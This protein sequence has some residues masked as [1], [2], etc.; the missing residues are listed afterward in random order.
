MPRNVYKCTVMVMMYMPILGVVC[1]KTGRSR[2]GDSMVGL[3]GIILGTWVNRLARH[4][5]ALPPECADA[6]IGQL[7]AA[8]GQL[9]AK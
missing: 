3:T 4:G 9:A 8:T 7:Y 2:S 1:R 6:N 5:Y